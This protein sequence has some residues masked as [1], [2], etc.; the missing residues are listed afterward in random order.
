[1][2]FRI[3]V[4]IS[5]I[6][7]W[8]LYFQVMLTAH[9]FLRS[10]LESLAES[11]STQQVLRS[12]HVSRIETYPTTVLPFLLRVWFVQLLECPYVHHCKS[13][14]QIQIGHIRHSIKQSTPSMTIISRW[15][16]LF[17]PGLYAII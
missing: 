1:M 9:V 5:P 10:R 11:K 8:I 14:W 2:K 17:L 13:C 7:R 15:F 6:P 3:L 12:A 16:D 4:V